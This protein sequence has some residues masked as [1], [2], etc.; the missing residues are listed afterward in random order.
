[1][2]F[3]RFAVKIASVYKESAPFCVLTL[4]LS[5]EEMVRSPAVR[6]GHFFLKKH[7]KERQ[8]EVNQ[9]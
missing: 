4:Q 2:L 3:G 9:V 8:K 7:T 6:S 5:L 1:M